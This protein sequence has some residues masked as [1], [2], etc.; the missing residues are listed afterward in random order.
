MSS[1]VSDINL[2]IT[3]FL[4]TNDEKL[5]DKAKILVYSL[6]TLPPS[7]LNPNQNEFIVASKFFLIFRKFF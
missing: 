1:V 7:N 4:S 3:Q 5:L 6:E 2:L